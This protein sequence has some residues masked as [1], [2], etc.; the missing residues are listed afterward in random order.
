MDK[1]GINKGKLPLFPFYLR[2]LKC[3]LLHTLFVNS[4]FNVGVIL[5]VHFAKLIVEVHISILSRFMKL[6][7][8]KIVVAYQSISNS[9]ICVRFP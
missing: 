3:M 1:K 7:I 6:N 2:F 9:I 5:V 8:H 4:E